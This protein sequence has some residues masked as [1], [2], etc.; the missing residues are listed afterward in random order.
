VSPRVAYAPLAFA[1]ATWRR[2]VQSARLMV[3]L[4]DYDAYVAHLRRHHP[5][6]EVPSRAAFFRTAQAARYGG[7]QGRC[8]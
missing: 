7:R 8:C 4:P 5:G 2:A 3:G 6:R 1:A